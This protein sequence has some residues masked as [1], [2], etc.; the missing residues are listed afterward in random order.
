M[1]N[2]LSDNRKYKAMTAAEA[3]KLLET[4]VGHSIDGVKLASA[5]EKKMA[6]LKAEFEEKAEPI[7]KLIKANAAELEAYILANPERFLKPRAR[8]TLFGSYGLRT[9]TNLEITDELA[10]IRLAREK[11]LPL[12]TEV[13]KLD[14][15][16][17]EKAISEGVKIPGAE[18]QT[19]ERAFYKESKE[20]IDQ[21]KA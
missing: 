3:D 15:K 17:V 13:I 19:G 4:I 18:I 6:A 21:A 12:F 7:S 1:N 2:V 8:K 16:A 14:K 11:A 9:V 20:L 10:V 5:Y